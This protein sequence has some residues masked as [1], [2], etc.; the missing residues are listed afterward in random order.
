MSN[1]IEC[2]IDYCDP[3]L[4]PRQDKDETL[5]LQALEVPAG[6]SPNQILFLQLI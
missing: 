5:I 1:R 6:L 4:L 3:R 2:V